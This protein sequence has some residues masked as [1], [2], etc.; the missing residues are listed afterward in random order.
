MISPEKGAQTTIYLATSPLIN[1][2][3]GEYFAKGKMAKTTRHA[4]DMKVADR[5]WEV[6]EVYCGLVQDNRLTG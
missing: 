3:S 6:S 2:I 5:L 1:G 4:Q